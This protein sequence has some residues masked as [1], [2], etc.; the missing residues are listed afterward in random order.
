MNKYFLFG[1]IAPLALGLISCGSAPSS[2][3]QPPATVT[4][5]NPYAGVVGNATL[6]PDP[7]GGVKI[8]V[9]VKGLTPG[10]HGIHIHTTG[11]CEGFDFAS[12]GGH[13]NPE[14]KQHGAQNPQGPHAGDLPNL[15]VAADGVGTLEYVDKLVSLASGSNSLFKT[16][17][18]AIVIHAAEDD[19]KT[20]PAGNSGARIACGVIVNPNPAGATN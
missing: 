2:Q 10:R 11:K 8:S 12:A 14:N 3:A 15:V 17:G 13:F 6:A 16:D 9:Q 20:D 19:E 4:L 5:R 7:A 1:I 18:T